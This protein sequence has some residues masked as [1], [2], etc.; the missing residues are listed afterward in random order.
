MGREGKRGRQRKGGDGKKGR[1]R[2]G[3]DEKEKGRRRETRP[4]VE[5]S[6]YTTA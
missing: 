5:I 4:P 6:G 3:R 1:K 2:E